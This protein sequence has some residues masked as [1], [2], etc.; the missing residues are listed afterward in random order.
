[1]P[2]GLPVV[3]FV[4]FALV[5]L[6]AFGSLARRKLLSSW[7]LHAASKAVLTDRVNANDIELVIPLPMFFPFWILGGPLRISALK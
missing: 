7:R 3:A 2:D 4:G 6:F 1:M 5:T